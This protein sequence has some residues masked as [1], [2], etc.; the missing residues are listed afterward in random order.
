MIGP[1]QWILR[2]ARLHATDRERRSA[3][4]FVRHVPGE[5]H[6]SQ[7]K[8]WEAGGVAL[9]HGLVR[10][11]ETALQLPEGQLLRAIDRIARED[12][13]LLALPAVPPPPSPDLVREA[14]PLLERALV[15]EPMSGLQWD[16]LTTLMALTPHVLLRTRDWATLLHR[17]SL[18]TA[19]STGL[20]YAH[21]WEAAARIVGNAH[22]ADVVIELIEGALTDDN[23]QLYSDYANLLRF[24]PDSRGHDILERVITSPTNR[25]AQWASFSTVT[26]IVHHGMLSHEHAVAILPVALEVL[27]DEQV[28]TRTRKAAASLSLR[29]QIKMS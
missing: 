22:V 25:R 12:D 18:E 13:P 21:R 28:P 23:E 6:R 7:V 17:L 5:P 29:P 19:V 9:T 11:Y 16:R 20:E 1:F 27:A 3:A 10:R 15:Y 4:G 24:C 2:N 14:M 8:R 26:T